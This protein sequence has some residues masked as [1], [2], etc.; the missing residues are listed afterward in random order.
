ME[1]K[2]M[3]N[4]GVVEAVLRSKDCPADL[5]VEIVS[6]DPDYP[7]YDKLQNYSDELYTDSNFAS[8]DYTCARFDMEES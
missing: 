7:D 1:I 2:V 6:V 3:I 5:D 4:R 8:A